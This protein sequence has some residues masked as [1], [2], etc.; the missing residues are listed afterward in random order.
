AKHV[1][2]F[3]APSRF[4]QALHHERGLNVPIVHLPHFVPAADPGVS[5][6]EELTDEAPDA[7]YFLF[8]GRLEKLKGLQ[9]LIPIFRR[10]QKAQLWI[11]GDG[12]Y[13]PQ[14]RRLAKGTDNVRF[15]GYRTKD[16]LQELYRNA[17]AL[18]VPSLSFEI[19]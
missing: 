5:T 2:A 19:F 12:G 7:P 14:L 15:L 16:E 9:T 8:V 6:R 1:D 17:T 10:Y 4:S 3:I 13:L 11:A 18:V